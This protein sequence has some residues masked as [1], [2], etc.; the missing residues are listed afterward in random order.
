M[1]HILYIAIE[2]FH[3]NHDRE[4]KLYREKHFLD[5]E[6]SCIWNFV[7]LISRKPI[8]KIIRQKQL[9]IYVLNLYVKIT[10]IRKN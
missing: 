2:T 4:K 3:D 6:V 7:F 5:N 1:M 8:N 10:S 9:I